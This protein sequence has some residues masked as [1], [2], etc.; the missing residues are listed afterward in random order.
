MYCDLIS[1]LTAHTLHTKD[2]IASYAHAKLKDRASKSEIRI[3]GY[4]TNM[5]RIW[6]SLGAMDAH[7]KCQITA[8]GHHNGSDGSTS[9]IPP[10]STAN[11]VHIRLSDVQSRAENIS[12]SAP[13][14][15]RGYITNTLY[16]IPEE[17][18]EDLD[19]D[20]ISIIG[21]QKH[22]CALRSYEN[23][24]NSIFNF[25]R[26]SD[27]R[28]DISVAEVILRE[29]KDVIFDVN[30]IR[31]ADLPGD[32]SSSSNGLYMEEACQLMKYL[33]ASHHLTSLDITNIN[34]NNLAH[35][36][37]YDSIA[38]LL[39]YFIEGT[40]FRQ[41]LTEAALD[42]KEYVVYPEGADSP[43]HFFNENQSNR[44]W[45]SLTDS[46]GNLIACSPSDYE[47]A[48]NGRYSDR[49]IKIL[50]LL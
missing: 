9:S 1:P 22:L 3:T 16:F 43:I 38:T 26:L 34:Y 25:M 8:C 27:I 41:S 15:N 7:H 44:W 37:Y 20:Q 17:V 5:E 32:H 45:C 2:N 10:Q 14:V 40:S 50:D 13:K 47:N 42:K 12:K 24:T 18:F 6:L 33:G 49:L 21:V 28:N 46:S 48:K 35:S 23:C 39:W 11:V 36:K 29:S 19:Y 4:H 31:H 30:A